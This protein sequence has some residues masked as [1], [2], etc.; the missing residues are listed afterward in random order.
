[1]RSRMVRLL[2]VAAYAGVDERYISR[3]LP[4]AFLA[5]AIVEAILQ[6]RQSADLSLDRLLG[7][8][9]PSWERQ[10]ARFEHDLGRQGRQGVHQDSG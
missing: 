2:A 4:C 3:I 7:H 5:P 1:M 10:C 9:P 8:L 6:G